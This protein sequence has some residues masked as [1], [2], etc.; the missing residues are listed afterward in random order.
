MKKVNSS[1]IP[2]QYEIRKKTDKDVYVKLRRNVQEKTIE[3]EEGITT[4]YEYDEVEVK[5]PNQRDIELYIVN[6]FEALYL[7]STPEL[8][9]KTLKELQELL[10]DMIEEVLA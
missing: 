9:F 2:L 5:I 4:Y 8:S 3:N 1:L 7:S 10:A 6:N